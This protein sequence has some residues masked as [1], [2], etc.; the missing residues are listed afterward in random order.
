[1]NSNNIQAILTAAGYA[2]RFTPW[3]YIM[4]KEMLPVYNGSFLSLLY[5]MCL[6]N[7]TT[8]VLEIL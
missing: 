1:M 6:N 5:N 7:Y 4:P 2:T 3:S 8:S